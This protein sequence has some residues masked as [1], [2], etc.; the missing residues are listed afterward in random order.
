MIAL[1]AEAGSLGAIEAPALPGWG[2]IEWLWVALA[3]AGL[4]ASALFSGLE[5]GIYTLDRVKLAVGASAGVPAAV[6]LQRELDRPDRLLA[7]LLVGNNAVNY[8]GTLAIAMLLERSGV[9]PGAAIVVNTAVVVPSLLI[10]GEILPK[11]LFR[12]FTDRWTYRFAGLLRGLRWGLTAIG[13]L[14]LVLGIGRLASRLLGEA[15]TPGRTAAARI[16]QLVRE[17]AGA[18]AVSGEQASMVD[19]ALS[20]RRRRV[21]GE[22]LPWAQVATVPAEAPPST[23]ARL[24]R[25]RPFSRVP[26]VDRRGRV[27]GVLAALDALLDPERATAD[28]MT[29]PLRLAPDLPAMEAL[30]Q[31]RLAR[32]R[33]A[34]VENA[35]GAPEGIV[36][37]KDLVEPLTGD[38]VAW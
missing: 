12:T 36:S 10:L 9:A 14:P 23:R 35:A 24:L 17:G 21:S 32:A 15:P 4:G 1:L 18:G 28:L 13:V 27:V 6:R 3:L 19:R 26:V 16:G 5:I 20:M 7:T 30:R 11:D 29:P 33:M 2:A 22:M 8:L 25:D 37:V 31:M 34:I 38:L